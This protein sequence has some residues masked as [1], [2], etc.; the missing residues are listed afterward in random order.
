[1]LALVSSNAHSTDSGLRE[2]TLLHSICRFSLWENIMWPKTSKRCLWKR[3][4][5]W[6]REWNVHFFYKI[7]NVTLERT[8]NDTYPFLSYFL[9]AGNVF[10]G[11]SSCKKNINTKCLFA[12]PHL[13]IEQ[14][15]VQKDSFSSRSN[16]KLITTFLH[17]KYRLFIRSVKLTPI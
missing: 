17:L 1:M 16:S 14:Y 15:F 8:Q 11:S 5:V 2:V 9:K 7:P 13:H 4:S 3:V 6:C 10:S 12:S